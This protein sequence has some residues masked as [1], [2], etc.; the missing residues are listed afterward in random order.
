MK[1][2]KPMDA[3]LFTTM[4]TDHSLTDLK[5]MQYKYT[6]EL[7]TEFITLLQKFFYKPL[8]LADFNQNP[9]VYLENHIHI[10]LNTTQILLAKDPLNKP[11]SHFAMTDEIQSSLSIENIQTSRESIR[12]ILAGYAPQ[13]KTE[14]QLYGMKKGLDFISDRKHFITEENLHL[15]YQLAIG[16]YLEDENRLLPSHYYRHD[17]VYLIS[18]QIEHHGLSA[19]KLPR[20][21]KQLVDFIGNN[22]LN[23]LLKAAITHFYMGYLHPYFDGN[24]RMAR[25]MHLWILISGGY[26]A[27][28]FV[29]F[30][31]HIEATKSKY[32]RAFS[33]VEDNQKISGVLDVTPFLSYFIE[34]VYHQL[35][36]TKSEPSDLLAD[37][38]RQLSKGIIT[39]K[40]KDLFLFVLSAYG[41]DAFST[42][43]L[44]KDF[45]NAAYATIRS[46][47]LKF[48]QLKLLQSHKYGNRNRYFIPTGKPIAAGDQ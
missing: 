36:P 32:Y 15:L 34:H 16:D 27:A 35:S 22:P 28:L 21:M 25:L 30:S 12:H 23:A 1:G 40:E 48:T 5:K 11:Y 13:N 2:G 14:N 44:E 10:S 45:G 43:Q 7:V 31:N 46:F 37:F 20:A 41:H 9:L 4:L 8:P 33:L 6:P 3:T 26:S 17:A 39:E 29:P 19:E 38:E 42:K 18:D 47:V 24:G